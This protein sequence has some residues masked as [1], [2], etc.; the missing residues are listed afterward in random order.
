MNDDDGSYGNYFSYSVAIDGN[1]AVIGAP[2]HIRDSDLCTGAVYAFEWDGDGWNLEAEITPQNVDYYNYF[3]ISVAISGNSM[4]AGAPNSNDAFVFMRDD[5]GNWTQQAEL[6]RNDTSTAYYGRSVDIY[7]DMAV[8]GSYAGSNAGSAEIFV[9]DA[10]GNWTLNA[11]MEEVGECA[12]GNNTVLI[13]YANDDEIYTHG[14]AAFVYS[15]DGLEWTQEAKIVPDDASKYGQ[16]GSS[17]SLSEDGNTALI[18]ARGDDQGTQFGSAY[19]YV[20]SGTTW[21]LQQKLVAEF[22]V[23]EGGGDNFGNSVS[24]SK[25][26][27]T[28]VVGAFGTNRYSSIGNGYMYI[29]THNGEEWTQTASLSGSSDTFGY[30]V[31]I[32]GEDIMAGDPFGDSGNGFASYVGLND[33]SNSNNAPTLSPTPENSFRRMLRG[34]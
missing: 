20:R 8:V 15:Y 4:I 13:G 32:S 22:D 19:V 30:V 24:L 6:V 12:L 3:G 33:E 26:G 10:N 1:I 34:N 18:G 14:G 31:A 17:V 7:G 27:D 9:R 5:D 11:A 2:N 25:S 28:L 16:F 21:T 23:S 29:Y